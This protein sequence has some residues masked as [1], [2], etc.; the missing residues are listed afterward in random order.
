MLEELWHAITS[1]VAWAMPRG[2]PELIVSMEERGPVDV[3]RYSGAHACRV[4]DHERGEEV[5]TWLAERVKSDRKR[6][7]LDVRGVRVAFG[8]G[9]GDMV[10][11]F[12]ALCGRDAVMIAVV[13]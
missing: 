9:V 11:P 10:N 2:A 8:S 6:Y 12:F 1:A 5:N 4:A 3:A 13:W 7:L